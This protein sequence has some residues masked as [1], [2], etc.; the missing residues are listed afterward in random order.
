MKNINY[1]F[2]KEICWYKEVCN[3][4]N[5]EL[6]C[7]SCIRYL[8]MYHLI[9]QSGIPKKFQYPKKLK[10][11]KEDQ[12]S[13]DWLTDIKNNIREI[14]NLGQ[15]LY[16]YSNKSGNGKTTWATKIMLK[17]FDEVWSGNGF[18]CKGLF[19]HVPTFLV[20]IKNAIRTK[21]THIDELIEQIKKVPLVIFDDIIV[22][23]LKDYDY[24]ILLNILDQ[25]DFNKLSNIYTSNCDEEELLLKAGER[26]CSRIFG[27]SA[28]KIVLKGSDRRGKNA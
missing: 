13:F 24:T 22:L 14:V 26:I 25:R 16:L 8:E 18:E 9:E 5:T 1:K 11:N 2:I 28:Y 17:Y 4:Y 27:G 12:S 23:D 3:L 15:S 20:E 7:E 21:S 6:C 10:P 19:I